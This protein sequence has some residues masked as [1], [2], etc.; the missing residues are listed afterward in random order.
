ME[1][2]GVQTTNSKTNQGTDTSSASSTIDYNAFLQLLIAQMKNQDPTSPTDMSQYMSQFAQLSQVEQSIQTNTKLDSLL[3]SNAL[4]Q[5]DGLIGH[6][7][8]F[9]TSDGVETTGKI[10]SVNIIQG[11]AVATLE[12]GSKVLLGPGITIS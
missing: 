11:G 4:L 9:T 12:D 5:A 8:T 2:G 1:V 10:T 6:T 7:A 3:S